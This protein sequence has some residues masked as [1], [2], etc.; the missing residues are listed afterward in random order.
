[1]DKKS[2]SLGD[3]WIEGNMNKRLN[4]QMIGPEKNGMMNK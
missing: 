3:E 4:G 2:K 1:M